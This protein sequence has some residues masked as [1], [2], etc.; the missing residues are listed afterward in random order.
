[1]RLIN[2][3]STCR[4]GHHRHEMLEVDGSTLQCTPD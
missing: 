2:R 1:M 4:V 3:L